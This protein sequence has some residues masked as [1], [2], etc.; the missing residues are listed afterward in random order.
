MV[1]SKT[2]V[3]TFLLKF[4]FALLSLTFPCPS[5]SSGAFFTLVLQEKRKARGELISGEGEG[6]GGREL[7]YNWMVLFVCLKVDGLK[8]LRGWWAYKFWEGGGS[9]KQQFTVFIYL[10]TV[11]VYLAW[12]SCVVLGCKWGF[13]LLSVTR[14][15]WTEMRDGYF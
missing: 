4:I 3:Q 2:E 13:V 6:G 15:N 10:I 11:L 7:G 1:C 8:G 12:A 5:N 9:Y 14:T